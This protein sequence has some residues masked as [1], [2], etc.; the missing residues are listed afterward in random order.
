M[1]CAERERRVIKRGYTWLTRYERRRLVGY[2][3]F[4]RVGVPAHNELYAFS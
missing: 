2:L 3:M 4:G 1:C